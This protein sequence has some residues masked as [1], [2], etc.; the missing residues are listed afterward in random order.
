MRR[1]SRMQ[2]TVCALEAVVNGLQ[3]KDID[4]VSKIDSHVL[5][6]QHST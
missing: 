1:A 6:S 4:G 3:R 5:T 2:E